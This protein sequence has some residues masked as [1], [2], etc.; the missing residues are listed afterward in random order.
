MKRILKLSKYRNFG[1]E[2]DDTLLLNSFSSKKKNVGGLV[3]LIGANNSGKS[4]ILDSLLELGDK[5]RLSDKDVTYLKHNDEYKKPKISI[6][7]ID[8][9]IDASYTLSLKEGQYFLNDKN[10]KNPTRKE[11]D[12]D[13][14]NLILKGENHHI[15]THKLDEIKNNISDKNISL[16][17]IKNNIYELLESFYKKGYEN[18]YY[19]D[20]SNYK[21]FFEECKDIKIVKTF[22]EN[23]NIDF[24]EKIDKYLN[25]EYGFNLKPKIVK[26][27]ENSIH[28]SSMVVDYNNLN[29]STFFTSVFK[30]I[31]F[32]KEEIISAYKDFYKYHNISILENV[33]D[34]IT[35]K[36][37]IINKQFNKLYYSESDEYIFS[38]KLES[39]NILFGLTR[40]K[41]KTPTMIDTQSTG[42]TWFFNFYFNFIAN[43][44]LTCGDIIVMDEPATNLHPAGQTELRN[45]IKSFSRKNGLTFIV[46]THSPF[47]VDVD[48][49]DELRIISSENNISTIENWFFAVDLNDPNTLLPIKKSLTI[50]QHV[51]YNMDTEIIW[52]EG[53]TDYNYLTMFKKILDIKDIAFLPFNGVGKTNEEQLKII[54]CL[55]NIKF[56]KR[57]ILV[58]GD[59]AGKQMQKKCKDTSFDKII[60]ISDISSKEK[61]FVEIE[62]LF[63]E[64]DKEKFECIN[65][66]SENYKK[67][68]FS[69]MMKNYCEKSDFSEE[70][71]SN[72]KTLFNKLLDN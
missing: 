29:S 16:D 8:D 40:G 21:N 65:K 14:T 60:S 11:I 5:N 43:N 51:L 12:S 54:E 64:S 30:L 15:D 28:S 3:I 62:D 57:N 58:D 52:V 47:F 19:N 48:N 34:K 61:E 45:F 42:F 50:Q 69:S 39:K 27:T 23:R 37:N 59:T 10:K 71:I 67:A 20:Y 9:N 7:I 49:F 32:D 44:S 68:L 31:N 35:K 63:S 46:A 55:N 72:F 18:N 1:L 41:E 26:Y 22:L 53:I 24:K 2:K 70:T 4:N 38:I 17:E 36:M 33:Q 13:L 56:Y 25:K 66:N 6:E